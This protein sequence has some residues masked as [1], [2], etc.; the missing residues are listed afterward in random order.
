MNGNSF[1]GKKS[2]SINQLILS[3]NEWNKLFY[4]IRN[5]MLSPVALPAL[6]DASIVFS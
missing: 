3:E 6:A 4:R 5:E 1:D 2:E